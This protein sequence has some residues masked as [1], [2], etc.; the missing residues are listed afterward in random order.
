MCTQIFNI[1][2]KQFIVPI[3]RTLIYVKLK[4]YNTQI[5]GIFICVKETFLGDFHATGRST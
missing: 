1:L 4:H 2:H 3:V 5:I